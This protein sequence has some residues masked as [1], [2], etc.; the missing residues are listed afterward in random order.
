MDWTAIWD[1]FNL[2]GSVALGVLV[3]GFLVYCYI[4]GN[5]W[6]ADTPEWIKAVVRAAERGDIPENPGLVNFWPDFAEN[7][8]EGMTREQAKA[9]LQEWVNDV[10]TGRQAEVDREIRARQDAEMEQLKAKRRKEWEESLN[11]IRC[12]HRL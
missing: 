7:E 1:A 5:S 10:R 6:A 12:C 2:W 9:K 3:L 11:E 8:M 4:L